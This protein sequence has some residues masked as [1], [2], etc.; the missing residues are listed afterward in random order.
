MT[1]HEPPRGPAMNLDLRPKDKPTQTYSN[2]FCCCQGQEG[3]SRTHS[4]YTSSLPSSTH[5]AII[6]TELL[7]GIDSS[8]QLSFSWSIPRI[9]CAS[10]SWLPMVSQH[11]LGQPGLWKPSWWSPVSSGG[12]PWERGATRELGQDKPGPDCS[13]LPFGPGHSQ[14][15]SLLS[16]GG[17]PNVPA[18]PGEPSQATGYSGCRAVITFR[19]HFTPGVGCGH[20]HL[21]GDDT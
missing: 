1:W 19:P 15:P 21:I 10:S 20:S 5:V 8:A 2:S 16:L 11:V 4:S 9:S 13:L 7:R 18:A 17:A 3:P 14:M 12:V 6:P